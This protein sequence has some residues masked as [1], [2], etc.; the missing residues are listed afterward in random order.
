M[1]QDTKRRD[2]LKVLIPVMT[3]ASVGMVW[4]FNRISPGQLIPDVDEL[5]RVSIFE[6]RWLYTYLLAFTFFCPLV[7]GFIPRLSFYKV[8]PKV[9]LANLPVTIFF[10][11]WDVYFTRI[12]VWGFSPTYTSGIDWFGLPWEECM[13]FIIIPAACI[14][15]YWSLN[16]LYPK[17]PFASVEKGI[18][19]GLILLT[20]GVAILKWDNIYTSTTCLLTSGFLLYHLLF[21]KSGYRGHFYRAY[22]ISCIPFLLINGALTGGFTEGPVVMYDG[23]EYFGARVGTIPVDDFV[24]SFL[25]LF[26]NISLFE[27]FLKP[28]KV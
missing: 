1:V 21:V 23:D 6:T 10:I 17:Q 9:L 28:T 13:F 18:T 8:W 3:L 4:Y 5:T 22:I 14:F 25:M 20:L 27:A 11:A 16:I 2:W 19:I 24:Y 12:G 15:I 7:F 26:A